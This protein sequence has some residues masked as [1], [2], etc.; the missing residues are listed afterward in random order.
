MRKYETPGLASL[1]AALCGCTL[2][3]TPGGCTR[4]YFEDEAE[5]CEPDD[6]D[7]IRQAVKA[8]HQ[9]APNNA[10]AERIARECTWERAAECT[11][12]GYELALVTK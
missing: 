6:V 7:S 2:V 8:A 9:N 10:L 12:K 11:L 4:E 5:Y 1:E 3:V